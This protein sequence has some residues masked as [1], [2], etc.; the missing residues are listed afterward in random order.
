MEQSSAYHALGQ[1]L[2]PVTASVPGAAVPER[3]HWL[4]LNN[5][6]MGPFTALE[7]RRHTATLPG[8]ALGTL[9]PACAALGAGR[10]SLACR[11][12]AAASPPVCTPPSAPVGVSVRLL[13]A[14]FP[15]VGRGRRGRPAPP[16]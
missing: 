10:R 7:T 4:A 2:S 9:L 16:V 5:T 3:Q 14:G 6:E 15:P 1:L 12:T 13:C 8:E 11:C